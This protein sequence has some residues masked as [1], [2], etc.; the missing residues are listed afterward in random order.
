MLGVIYVTEYNRVKEDKGIACPKMS[1][2][3]SPNWG[4]MTEWEGWMLTLGCSNS[5]IY[6][7]ISHLEAFAEPTPATTSGKEDILKVM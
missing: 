6:V 3:S 4:I 1:T 2:S 7:G 5:C